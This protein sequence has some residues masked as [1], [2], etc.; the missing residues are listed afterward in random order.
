M[1]LRRR[2]RG[3]GSIRGRGDRAGPTSTA[4]PG[5]AGR[6]RGS[7]ATAGSGERRCAGVVVVL[8][9]GLEPLELL[10]GVD[11]FSD[12]EERVALE[13]DVDEGRLHPREHLG[14][15]SLVDVA[16]DAALI[17]ALDEDF[18]DLI[19]LENGHARIVAAPRR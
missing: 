2:A 11:D 15:P 18:D 1:R 10:D 7:S 16:D 13:P 4:L 12:V 9:T 19:V 14:D 8:V 3:R 17:L 5:G 6:R